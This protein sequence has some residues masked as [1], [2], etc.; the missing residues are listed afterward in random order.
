MPR[1]FPIAC[2]RNFQQLWR[3]GILRQQ[4]FEACALRLW[5][6]AQSPPGHYLP[7]PRGVDERC[8]E[9]T[10]LRKSQRIRNVYEENKDVLFGRFALIG[11]RRIG[12]RQYC[13]ERDRE[14]YSGPG[15][16]MASIAEDKQP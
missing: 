13:W 2:N 7:W 9:P 15:T 1:S 8:G 11:E 6:F 4:G 12:E 14:N 5:T 10:G 16:P 3:H